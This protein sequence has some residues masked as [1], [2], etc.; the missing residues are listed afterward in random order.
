MWGQAQALHEALEMDEAERHRRGEAI[1]A[2]V[3]ANDVTVW[4]EG[5]R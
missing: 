2:Q 3:R 5:L 4:L 1:R